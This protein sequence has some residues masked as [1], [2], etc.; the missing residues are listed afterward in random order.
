MRERLGFRET[1]KKRTRKRL[2]F[3]KKKKK[4]ERRGSNGGWTVMW[5]LPEKGWGSGVSYIF[6]APPSLSAPPLQFPDET[7]HTFQV[8]D[9]DQNDSINE[10]ELQEALSLHY[11]RF[12][13]QTIQLLMRRL[14]NCLARN[15]REALKCLRYV[16]PPSVITVLISKYNNRSFYHQGRLDFDCF[17]QCGMLVKK[18]MEKDSFRMGLTLTYAELMSMILPFPFL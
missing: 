9:R 18:F 1:K 3:R 14:I 6:M 13:L 8:V 2:G 10:L 17:V 4:E 5:G 12:C 7:T 15:L 16:V 11:P